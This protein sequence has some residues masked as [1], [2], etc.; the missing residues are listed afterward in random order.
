[1]LITRIATDDSALWSGKTWLL[2]LANSKLRLR[3]LHISQL[4][5]GDVQKANRIHDFVKSLSFDGWTAGGHISAAVV[6]K[7]GRGNCHSKSTLFVVLLRVLNISARLRF[8]SLSG[9][10]LRGIREVKKTGITLAISEVYLNG[11]G[12]KPIPM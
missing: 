9:A 4:V 12:L 10:F 1:M 11:N 2:D 7:S 5:T 3:A 6:L 8:V